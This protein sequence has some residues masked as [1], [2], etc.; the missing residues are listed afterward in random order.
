MFKNPTY[1]ST[2]SF[3]ISTKTVTIR[4]RCGCGELLTD[5]WFKT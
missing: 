2:E 5:K 4:R 3:S 1:N